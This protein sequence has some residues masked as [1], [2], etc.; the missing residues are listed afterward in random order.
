MRDGAAD[1]TAGKGREPR[2]APPGGP[3]G[4]T[5]EGNRRVTSWT[6]VFWLCLL[7]LV[8]VYAGYPLLARLLGGILDRRVQAGPGA[9]QRPRVTVLIAAFNEGKVIEHTLRK[10][11]DTDYGG[12]MEVV[13]VDDG[14]KDNTAEVVA[15]IAQQDPRVR[16]I[17]QPNMGKALA[18]RTP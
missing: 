13:V 12:P 1:D 10:L 7:G 16:L 18:L 3:P 2:R 8:Y 11:L 15:G 5:N 17:R 6:A 9:G 4:A 14:S